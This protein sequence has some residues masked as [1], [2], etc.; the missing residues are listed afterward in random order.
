[1]NSK[2]ELLEINSRIPQAERERD[3]SYLDTILDEMLVFKRA[4]GTIVDKSGY[5]SSVANEANTVGDIDQVVTGVEISE[6]DN[7][8]I[9][10]AIVKFDGARSGKKVQGIFRNTRYFRNEMGWKMFV[11]HN[12][13]QSGALHCVYLNEANS[14]YARN[15]SNEMNGVVYQEMS[16]LFPA[17]P[18]MRAINV[19][20]ENGGH[21]KWHFHEG[22][23][24][25]IGE[26]GLGFVEEKDGAI[27]DLCE[28][29]RV[30]IPPFVWHRHGARRGETL[31]HMA[32]TVGKTT[33]DFET[34]FEEQ[35]AIALQ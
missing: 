5:L 4:D 33:W 10:N 9:V 34:R 29:K 20:F 6:H 7:V 22:W 12:D 19:R 25:L 1:M 2:S 3:V 31:T 17:S 8:A 30:L 18:D 14:S 35:A 27:I 16:S 28:D 11:W 24:L 15:D 23:Q 32:V 21:T 13:K 26:K